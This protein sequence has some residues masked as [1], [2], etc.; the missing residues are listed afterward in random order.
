MKLGEGEKAGS[1]AGVDYVKPTLQ[2]PEAPKPRARNIDYIG[3]DEPPKQAP[4]KQAPQE[5]PPQKPKPEIKSTPRTAVS[6]ADK[7]AKIKNSYVI[8]AGI[9]VLGIIV[10]VLFYDMLM[11]MWGVEEVSVVENGAYSELGAKKEPD[12]QSPV[13]VKKDEITAPG[14]AAQKK[15]LTPPAKAPAD[16]NGD[17][18]KVSV[19]PE[20]RPQPAA[21]KLPGQTLPAAET[22]NDSSFTVVGVGANVRSGPGM[23]NDVVTVVKKGE[24][25]KAVGEKQGR[26]I[27]I[28]T[29]DGKEG[30]ISTKVIKQAR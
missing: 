27:K 12:P 13:S 23:G 15:S 18:A 16:V 28:Q 6:D 20:P 5:T 9:L 19:Q 8:G 11:R 24:V 26:W 25:F 29:P 3:P 21:V 2:Q 17:A 1:A 10:G 7:D 4:Q 22:G 14:N 30:W